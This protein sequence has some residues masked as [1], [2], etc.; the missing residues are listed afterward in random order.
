VEIIPVE[1]WRVPAMLNIEQM[2]AA[3][4]S[5]PFQGIYIYRVSD[6]APRAVGTTASYVVQIT[7]ANNLKSYRIQL[8]G[9]MI[10]QMWKDFTAYQY[11]GRQ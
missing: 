6:F 11:G 10:E 5:M 3:G 9:N 4:K 8:K 1:K 7:D 2:K